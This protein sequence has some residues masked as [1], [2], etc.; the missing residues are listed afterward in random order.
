[1]TRRLRAA[2]R[3]CPKASRWNW[4][5]WKS[6]MVA[7]TTGAAMKHAARTTSS[8]SMRS[9]LEEAGL[10]Q[11]QQ[12]FRRELLAGLELLEHGLGRDL[13]AGLLRRARATASLHLGVLDHVD[14]VDDLDIRLVDLVGFHLGDHEA[15]L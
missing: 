1:M 7:S 15:L 14:V 3:R 13:V 4:R 5:T 8:G 9:P 11:R 10:L 2:L 12:V 6:T